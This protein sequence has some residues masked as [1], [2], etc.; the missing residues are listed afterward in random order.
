M[1]PHCTTVILLLA[2][3]CRARRSMRDYG[4]RFLPGWSRKDVFEHFSFRE[5]HSLAAV[6]FCELC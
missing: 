1:G 4:H 2:V 6:E 3:D 5:S